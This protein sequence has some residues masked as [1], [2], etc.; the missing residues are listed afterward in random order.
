MATLRQ[1]VE[2]E[3]AKEGLYSHLMKLQA[4]KSRRLTNTCAPR[5]ITAERIE[6]K[7]KPN[8]LTPIKGTVMLCWAQR[9]SKFLKTLEKAYT[10]GDERALQKLS[11]TF[12]G[13]RKERKVVSVE[14]AAEVIVDAPVHFDFLYGNKTL[15][16]FVTL[17]AKMEFG[18]M[19]FAYN[20]GKL[21]DGEFKIVDH[22][23]AFERAGYDTLIVKIPPDLTQ[24]EEEALEAVPE[25][26]LGLNLG[27]SAICPGI[28]VIVLIVVALVTCANG[29]CDRLRDE[30]A[31]VS[32]PESAIKQLGKVASARQLLAMRRE[33]LEKSGL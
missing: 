30:L 12:D 27:D 16:S 24:I 23:N 21:C 19:G 10:V 1:D 33:V 18:A 31:R 20:G 11:E 6:S 17:P 8:S 25:T 7:S 3:F 22:Y 26:Q 2:A 4:D 29:G 5:V 28:T 13:W 15:A 14:R 32:L 9:G